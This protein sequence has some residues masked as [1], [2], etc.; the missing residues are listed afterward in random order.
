MQ[1]AGNQLWHVQHEGCLVLLVGLMLQLHD[2]AYRL[3][4]RTAA[5]LS[6]PQGPHPS[7]TEVT[8]NKWVMLLDSVDAAKGAWPSNLDMITSQ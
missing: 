1:S 3:H 8:L 6:E 2:P 4:I 5:S 7:C